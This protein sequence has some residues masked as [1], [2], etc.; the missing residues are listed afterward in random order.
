MPCGHF[1]NTEVKLYYNSCSCW[2]PWSLRTCFPPLFPSKRLTV[3]NCF[4]WLATYVGCLLLSFT[5][6]FYSIVEGVVPSLCFGYIGKPQTELVQLRSPNSRGAKVTYGSRKEGIWR[7]LYISSQNVC[8]L[9]V[10]KTGYLFITNV[11]RLVDQVQSWASF[12]CVIVLEYIGPGWSEYRCPL[13]QNVLFPFFQW[14][15]PFV[16]FSV[17]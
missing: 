2:T 8:R 12:W 5:W 9:V 11:C 1:N 7:R 15:S 17:V 13:Y 6:C 14:F 16:I 4:T 10:W 3:F